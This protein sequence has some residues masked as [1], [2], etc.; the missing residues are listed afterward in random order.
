M[1]DID[2]MID[3]LT[4]RQRSEFAIACARRVQHLMCDP[5]S[6]DAL[7]TRDRWLRGEATNEEMD[8]AWRAATIAVWDAEKDKAQAQASARGAACGAACG[9]GRATARAAAWAAAGAATWD[10]KWT[11][12]RAWQREELERMLQGGGA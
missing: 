8:A 10:D 6:I 1:S 4:D 11:A 2:D 3:R 7:D 12:E 9:A 5:R